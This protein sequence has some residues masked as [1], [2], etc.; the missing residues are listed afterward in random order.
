MTESGTT[1]FYGAP[2]WY[3]AL[4]SEARAFKEQQV[5]DQFSIVRGV[6]EARQTT[7]S[8]SGAGSAP[9]GTPFLRAEFGAAAV[10][11]A[12]VFL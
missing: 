4:P 7:R 5:Q 8:S 1:T 9:T 12:G 10:L 3:S 2:T 11:A 6:I